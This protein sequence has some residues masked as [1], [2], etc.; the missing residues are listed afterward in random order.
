[1]P[2][3]NRKQGFR[4]VGLAFT[5]DGVAGTVLS[6]E[7]RVIGA[8]RARPIDPR[9]AQQIAYLKKKGLRTPGE[10]ALPPLER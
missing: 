10:D 4:P 6:S 7:G 8:R 1:M 3:Q 5:E 2:G 9:T